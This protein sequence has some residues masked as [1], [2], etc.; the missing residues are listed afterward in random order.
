MRSKFLSLIFCKGSRNG[1]TLVTYLETLQSGKLTEWRRTNHFKFL[2]LL[3]IFFSLDYFGEKSKNKYIYLY[4]QPFMLILP[5]SDL[6]FKNY[7]LCNKY[8]YMLLKKYPK[9]KALTPTSATFLFVM[10]FVHFTK[11]VATLFNAICQT[12]W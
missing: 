2:F 9:T 1:N 7:V 6:T 5:G 8:L 3:F 4:L 12:W 11:F 10:S